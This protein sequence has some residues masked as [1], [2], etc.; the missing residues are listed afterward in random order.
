MAI[1]KEYFGVIV[2]WTR[3]QESSPDS[4]FEVASSS[5]DFEFYLIYS[6][7]HFKQLIN[8]KKILS[9]VLFSFEF[10]NSDA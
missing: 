1:R 3:F 4:K 2:N 7:K 5:W 8:T 9:N 6:V 10:E